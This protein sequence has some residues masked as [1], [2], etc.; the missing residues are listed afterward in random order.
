MSYL[1]TKVHY[2]RLGWSFEETHGRETLK[3]IAE[4][5]AHHQYDKGRDSEGLMQVLEIDP[6]AGTCADVTKEVCKIA[7]HYIAANCMSADGNITRLMNEYHVLPDWVSA[8]VEGAWTAAEIEH[9]Q[10]AA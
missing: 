3:E 2:G 4:N 6:E 1:I 5:L 7:E 10:V 8:I 9:D